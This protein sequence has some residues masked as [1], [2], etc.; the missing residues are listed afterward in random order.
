TQVGTVVPTPAGPPPVVGDARV[1]GRLVHLQC[2][3]VHDR[4]LV[5]TGSIVLHRAVVES[6]AWV[7]AG[8]VVPND[9]IVPSGMMALGVPAK[10][11]H[12]S[13]D[14]AEIGRPAADYVANAD[15][16]RNEESL[17]SRQPST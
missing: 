3:T 10:L 2:C 15:R 5:G 12:G 17:I 11:R 16:Y 1:I 9:M 4:S 13:V 14:A 8:A 7:G 6:G